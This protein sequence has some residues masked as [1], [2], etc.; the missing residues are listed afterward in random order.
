MTI[1]GFSTMASAEN[2]A[3]LLP[4]LLLAAAM[5]MPRLNRLRA[6]AALA[7]LAGL[8]NAVLL[9]KSLVPTTGWVVLLLAASI[10][11]THR[12]LKNRR[13]R[14]TLEEEAMVAGILSDLSPARAR[15]LLDQGFWLS[16]KAGDVLTREDEPVTHLFYLASG[17]ARVTSH[18]RQVGRVHS[19]DLIGEVTVLSGDQASATVILTGPARFWCAPATTLRPYLR[20]H[21]D[22]RRAL[23]HGFAQSLRAKLR[24]SNE[25]IVAGGG[26]AA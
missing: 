15:H 5:F 1:A 16:G 11:V 18:G 22:V 26:I 6:V 8:A 17:E 4:F 2:L 19:G 20:H 7:A 13:V 14:F 21:Q 10:L 9:E 24:A 12:L 23:E 3:A 25:T